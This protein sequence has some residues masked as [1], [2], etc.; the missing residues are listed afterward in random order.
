[1]TRPYFV[2]VLTSAISLWVFQ[3]AGW[4]TVSKMS[5]ALPQEHETN[6]Q[7][8]SEIEPLS[9]SSVQPSSFLDRIAQRPD[10]N[11]DRLLPSPGPIAP[12]EAIDQTPVLPTAPSNT[13]APSEAPS[14]APVESPVPPSSSP[15]V[16]AP[17]SGTTIPVQSIN[18]LGSTVFD[19]DDLAFILNP[20]E[21][22]NVTLTE[23]QQ[24]AD[25]ITQLYLNEGYL[26]SRAILIAQEVVDGVV[27]IQI[28]EGRIGEIQVEGT[29]RLKERYVR[30]RIELGTN[31][32][33]RTDQ[34][35]NQLRLLRSDPL[36]ENVEA[37]LRAGDE[38][39][40]SKLI[41]KVTEADP[42]FGS[43]RADNYSPPSVGSERTGITLAHRN[44][45]GFADRLS[46]SYDRTTQGGSNVFDFNYQIPVNPMEGTIQLRTVIENNRVLQEPFDE[47][48][49]EG[50]SERY[51]ISFRQPLVRSPREEFALS[52]GFSHRDGQ[53]LAFDLIPIGL[54]ANDQGKTSTSVFRFGQ[55]YVRRDVQGA[56]A[57]RSQFNIGT[58]LFDATTNDQEPDSEFLSW[59]GQTQ[60]V[61]RLGNDHLLIFQ[62]DAQ[63]TDNALLSSEQFVIGGGQSL[64]GYRQ[65][66][67]A[68]DSGLRFSVEDRITIAR[69]E[70][71]AAT[72]Q[73]IPF[74]DMGTV[75]NDDDNAELA[76]Q[77]FLAGLGLGMY[78]EIMPNV[79]VRLDF[80]IPLVDLDDRGFNIQDDGIY[81]SV[82]YEL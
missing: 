74:F 46:I 68:G 21:G 38:L 24:A 4:A 23:L 26:T 10:P 71:G 2:P 22:Q 67:R 12:P 40:E 7:N 18:V 16:P 52:L 5:D 70:A 35:E 76:D 49:I 48:D 28:I 81:F 72:F 25:A 42:L 75:W 37:S 14:E 73:L 63:L 31:I 19:Q 33:L 80:G 65:N 79:D 58:G 20:L 11:A 78:W 43:V 27:T 13:E 66:A 54:G 47:F 17:Q 1:M 9:E 82:G 56:W 30:R 36:L 34:L 41:V 15:T 60:R 77:R 50:E 64:R 55:E 29:E 57:L 59:L 69:N 8:N 44:L 53:T 39:G 45:T 6:R 62:L 61:Q 51:E 32:P 3:T